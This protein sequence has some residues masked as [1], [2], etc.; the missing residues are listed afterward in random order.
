M[1]RILF[2]ISA[3]ENKSRGIRNAHAAV[4]GQIRP[5]TRS[6]ELRSSGRRRRPLAC[7]RIEEA[8]AFATASAALGTARLLVVAPDETPPGAMSK[9]SDRG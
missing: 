9:D 8:L 1:D 4:A 2:A 7:N 5:R 3:H 6:T